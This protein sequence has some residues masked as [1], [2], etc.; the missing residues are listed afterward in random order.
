MNLVGRSYIAVKSH[1]KPLSDQQMSNQQALTRRFLSEWEQREEIDA[2]GLLATSLEYTV[3]H[4]PFYRQYFAN[5]PQKDASRL[6]DWPILTRDLLRSYFTDL[7][8]DNPPSGKSW[9][10]AS[11]GSTGKPVAVVHDEYFA[12][13]AQALRDLCAKIF[14]GG[15]HYNKLI[16]WGMSEEV[17]KAK[18]GD[19][20]WKG[21][22]KDKLLQLGGLKTTH[23]NTFDFT[24]QKFEECIQILKTQKPEFIFGYGESIYQ[25]A[26]YLDQ[27]G[28][29]PARTPKKI[30]TTAQTLYPFMREKIEEVFGCS[31]CD[32]YGSR[33][34]GPIAW[35]HRNGEMYFPKF[36]SR[37]EVVDDDGS[38]ANAGESGRVL[39]TT[40]HNY[41]MP[42]IRYE[43]GDSG[44]QGADTHYRGYPFTTLQQ[45]TGK[46]NEEFIRRDGTLIHGQFFTNLFYYRPWIDEFH[47]VQKD[48]E[49]VE[50]LYVQQGDV[51]PPDEDIAEIEGRIKGVM[52]NDCTVH[53]QKVNQIPT[54]PAGKRL[55]IRSE[56]KREL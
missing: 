50:I 17:E 24:Q 37:I 34:V 7:Q 16:L 10:H 25:L 38:A 53:W 55:Y 43:I 51:T 52:T 13:K 33:E 54:T 4:V 6:A 18:R 14:F 56:V 36:F 19:T 26:K 27:Q 45:I 12:A 31:V 42:L 35:Q 30:G 11:G 5:N 15:P 8:S 49:L 21:E 46:S 32:H 23:I 39:V 48:Y 47:V 2:E 3:C 22:I 9:T 28:V 40:L 20:S 1:I 44:V 29:R 41:T